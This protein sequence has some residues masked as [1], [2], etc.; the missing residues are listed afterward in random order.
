M[1]GELIRVVRKY[2]EIDD[3]L[4][5]VNAKAN[6]LREERKI[7]EL[8]M[9]DYLKSP[10][11]AGINKLEISDDNTVIRIQ[12]PE[13][14]AKPWSLSARDLKELLS[15]YWETTGPKS[16]EDCFKYIVETRKRDLV[17]TEFSFTRTPM[18]TGSEDA[19]V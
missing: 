2:R 19:N 6:K 14:W 11:Y 9:A 3:R 8:E 5:E 18:K 1:S 12:R 10:K 15:D 4:K 16:A 7:T 13:A 17:S